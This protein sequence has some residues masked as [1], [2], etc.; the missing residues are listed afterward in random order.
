MSRPLRASSAHYCYHSSSKIPWQAQRKTTWLLTAFGVT[1]SH[2]D[3]H[4]SLMLLNYSKAITPAPPPARYTQDWFLSR[5]D[6]NELLLRSG[7]VHLNIA[8]A[9]WLISIR[10]FENPLLLD[11]VLFDMYHTSL[12]CKSFGL[13]NP[14]KSK[15]LMIPGFLWHWLRSSTARVFS[16]VRSVRAEDMFLLIV[17]LIFI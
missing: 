6:Q 12:Y 13:D 3:H 2:P 1:S 17:L 15:Q 10:V 5:S 14:S 4:L 7:S 16:T 11:Y 8:S 9:I